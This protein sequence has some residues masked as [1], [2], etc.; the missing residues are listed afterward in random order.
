M[1]VAVEVLLGGV[2]QSAEQT[3]GPV[4]EGGERAGVGAADPVFE[5]EVDGFL[6]A[7]PVVALF[8]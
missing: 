7:L 3:L 8:E 4:E 5:G 1:L 2:L 6:M